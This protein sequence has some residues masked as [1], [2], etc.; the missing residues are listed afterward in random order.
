M[1]VS[2][3]VI[4]GRG[5][6]ND[7]ADMQTPSQQSDVIT[8]YGQL[9]F[10]LT[11]PFTYQCHAIVNA[12]IQNEGK[13]LGHDSLVFHRIF[14]SCIALIVGGYVFNGMV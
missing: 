3:E 13:P 5:V 11:R 12:V 8:L 6:S 2:T 4:A 7:L 9:Y 14:H 10:L 1:E